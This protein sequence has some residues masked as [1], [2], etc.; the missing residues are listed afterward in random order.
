[1]KYY[2]FTQMLH[3]HHTSNIIYTYIINITHHIHHIHHHSSSRTSHK[4]HTSH[5]SHISHTSHTSSTSHTS[6]KSHTS[7]TSHTCFASGDDVSITHCNILHYIITLVWHTDGLH[8][9]CMHESVSQYWKC[10]VQEVNSMIDYTQLSMTSSITN[11]TR[12]SQINITLH[13][14]HKTI[15]NEHHITNHK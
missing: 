11:N 3:H 10:K 13:K 12:Q 5:T 4:S 8:Q 2:A 14:H 1:M 6:H 15:H 7:S 9:F